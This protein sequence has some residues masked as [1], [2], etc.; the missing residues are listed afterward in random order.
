MAIENKQ[1]VAIF[2]LNSTPECFTNYI[3]ASETAISSKKLESKTLEKHEIVQLDKK[4]SPIIDAPIFIDDTVPL[5]VIHLKNKIKQFIKDNSLKIVFIENL[6]KI[7]GKRE[8]VIKD[9]NRLALELQIPIIAFY[10][11]TATWVERIGPNFKP[12]YTGLTILDWT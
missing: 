11:L 1:E 2:G 12:C 4:I 6:E 8:L 9:L 10:K 3:L 5:S 7:V